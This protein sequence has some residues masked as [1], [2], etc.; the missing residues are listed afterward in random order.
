MA[1]DLSAIK[2]RL[3]PEAYALFLRDLEKFEADANRFAESIAGQTFDASNT[4]HLASFLRH[5]Y[6]LGFANGLEAKYRETS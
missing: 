6:A 5:F 2:S 4:A 1:T 3:T